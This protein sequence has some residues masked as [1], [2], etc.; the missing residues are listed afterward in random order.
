MVL[1]QGSSSHLV[2]NNFGPRL[3]GAPPNVTLYKK[4]LG[5][6]ENKKCQERGENKNCLE[7]GENKKCQERRE[8]KNCLETGEN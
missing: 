3:F 5:K 8:N 7:T 2:S 1:D 6:E 4:C